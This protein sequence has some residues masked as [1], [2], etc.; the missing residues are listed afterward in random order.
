MDPRAK[1]GSCIVIL[2]A[3]LGSVISVIRIATTWLIGAS[4]GP[5]SF[6]SVPEILCLSVMET[7]VGGIAI[8]LAVLKPLAVRFMGTPPVNNRMNDQQTIAG[9]GQPRTLMSLVPKTL[10]LASPASWGRNRVW[11]IRGIGFLP[12]ATTMNGTLRTIQE[13]D[14]LDRNE[15]FSTIEEEESECVTPRISQVYQGKPL[16]SIG[17]VLQWDEEALSIK[18]PRNDS[19]D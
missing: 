9:Q 12:D 18:G 13:R 15:R 1:I 10:R 7:F 4:F 3:V 16:P 2:L 5:Q 6:N 14:E 8:S 19:L 11:P 17:E